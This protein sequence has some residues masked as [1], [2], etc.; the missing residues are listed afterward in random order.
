[1]IMRMIVNG[2]VEISDVRYLE[3][4]RIQKKAE[5]FISAFFVIVK[6]NDLLRCIYIRVNSKGNNCSWCGMADIQIIDNRD[7]AINDVIKA[8]L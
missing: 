7:I 3:H 6:A 4:Q 5:K 2:K 1:M 8:S